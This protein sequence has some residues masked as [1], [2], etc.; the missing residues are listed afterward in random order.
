VVV[1]S[2]GFG[3]ALVGLPEQLAAAHEVAGRVPASALPDAAAFDRIVTLG[4]GG[5]GIAG[6]IVQAVGTAT[7]PVPVTVLKHYRTPAFV[8]DRTLAFALSYSGD[9]EE[10]VEMAR[11]AVAA[12]ATLVAISRGGAL[13]QL[14]QESGSLHVPCP[15]DILMPRLALGALV[16]PLVVVLFRMGMMPEAHAGLLR[17]QEQLAR[18][19][20]QCRPSVEGERNAAREL[21][22]KIGRTIPIVYGSGGLGGVAAMRWKQSMNENAKAPAFWNEYP[23]LD[24][25]EVCGWGQHGDVTRQV[26]TLV[27]LRH[28]LEHP[29]LEA[30]AVATRELIEEALVQVLGVEAEGEGRLAQLLDLIYMGDWTSY[31]VALDNDVDPGPIDAITQ[32]KSSLG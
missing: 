7:L 9:T 29:R 20:D 2:L 15:D 22:R 11:G 14:A 13:A 6:N 19:R 12:G 27:E 23:E 26:F 30:R 32:L 8:N 24:H 18:R 17:A 31:Y 16:A 25:N 21:A 28:G 5:S 10:T 1:D 3:E 4:M